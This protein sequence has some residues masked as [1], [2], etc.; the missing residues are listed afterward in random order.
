MM[1]RRSCIAA[2]ISGALLAGA[3]LPA[4]A[5]TGRVHHFTVPGVHGI[6][7]WGSYQHTGAR[8][9]ITVCVQDTARGVYGGA[10][11]AVAY[12]AARRQQTTAAVTVGL[13]HMSCQTMVTSDTK[14]LIVDAVSGW[15]DGKVRQAG[16]P[17]QIY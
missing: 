12:N 6:R 15:R 13:H 7:G 11:A 8:I 17:G 2:A 10:V 5:A 14:H 4:A 16:R 9:R 3:A 1:L